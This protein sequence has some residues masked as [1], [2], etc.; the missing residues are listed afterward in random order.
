[1]EHD[2]NEK[3]KKNG[4]K[5]VTVAREMR[6]HFY[7]STILVLNSQMSKQFFALIGLTIESE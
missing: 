6:M 2:W 5:Y 7:S 1:M 3:T 4:W